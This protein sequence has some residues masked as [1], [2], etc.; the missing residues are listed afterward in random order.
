[1]TAHTKILSDHEGRVVTEE[2]WSCGNYFIPRNR[3]E[4]EFTRSEGGEKYS[5][6]ICDDCKTK[7]RHELDW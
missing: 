6:F 7:K 1:M 4:N 3:F 5:I 2:C